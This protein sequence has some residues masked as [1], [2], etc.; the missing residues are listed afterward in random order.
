MR[1]ITKWVNDEILHLQSNGEACGQC[2]ST[3]TEYLGVRFYEPWK[4]RWLTNIHALV[5][6]RC[7]Y[8][9]DDC[10]PW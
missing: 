10:N 2:G 6:L 7:G 4:G 9:N 5:C 1:N 8:E 3:F